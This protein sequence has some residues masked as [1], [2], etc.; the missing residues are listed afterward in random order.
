MKKLAVLIILLMGIKGFSQDPELFDREWY[1][2]YGILNGEFFEQPIPNFDAFI[3]FEN[4]IF[5]VFH[6]Y[7]DEGT[8][9][10]IIYENEINQFTI[11]DEFIYI[12][13]FCTSEEYTFFMGQHYSIYYDAGIIAKNPFN[14]TIESDGDNYMLT[15][16]NGEGD[17]AVYGNVPLSQPE[18]S[19]L[20]VTLY[21]NPVKDVLHINSTEIIS[22]V[23]VYN[24]QGKVIKTVS[25]INSNTSEINLSSLQNGV[26]F[27]TI[28]SENGDKLSKKIVKK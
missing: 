14:Y 13:G 18:F 11:S 1:L 10:D 9:S 23:S 26:Y 12:I 16:E 27:V 21:P 2:H 7:C 5:H 3:Y 20:Q 24:I 6:Q 22:E 19:Q 28:L 25:E 4:I 8:Q 17:I 15:I